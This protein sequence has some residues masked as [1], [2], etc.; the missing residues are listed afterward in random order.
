MTGIVCY[1]QCHGGNSKQFLSAYFVSY[2]SPLQ[3]GTRNGS[4]FSWNL[5]HCIDSRHFCYYVSFDQNLC[6]KIR[7]FHSIDK[8][9]CFD[10]YLVWQHSGNL[11]CSCRPYNKKYTLL[12]QIKMGIAGHSVIMDQK[13]NN[14]YSSSLFVMIVIDGFRKLGFS[15]LLNRS[16]ILNG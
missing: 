2:F 5:L 4:F 1:Q 8:V 6:S 7:F 3:L 16:R 15:T 9:M 14:L 13:R 10:R 11:I 12:I